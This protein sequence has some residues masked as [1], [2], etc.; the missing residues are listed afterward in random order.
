MT[1]N[2]RT[3]SVVAFSCST[4]LSLLTDGHCMV[5]M[6]HKSSLVI[7]FSVCLVVGA[8]P[9]ENE[10]KQ[11]SRTCGYDVIKVKLNRKDIKN[12]IFPSLALQR[13]LV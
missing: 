12:S 3:V 5:I 7:F 6:L 4:K 13:K 8:L 11:A 2:K 10:G 9:T 1:I